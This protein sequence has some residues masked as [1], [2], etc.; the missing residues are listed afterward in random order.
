MKKKMFFAAMLSFALLSCKEKYADIPAES[1]EMVSLE[2][3]LQPEATKVSGE[4]GNEER[5]EKK[6]R[7]CFYRTDHKHIEYTC[8]KVA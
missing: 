1:R 5:K 3:K 7:N 2:I 4:G 6:R 8:E